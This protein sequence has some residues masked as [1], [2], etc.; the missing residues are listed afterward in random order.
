MV[1][2]FDFRIEI[3][4]CPSVEMIEKENSIKLVMMGARRDDTGIYTLKADNDHGQDQA[5][6]EVVVMV[7]PSKPRGPMK[8]NDIVADGCL[9]EWSAPE[10]DGG[11]PITQYIIE[12]AEGASVNWTVCGQT[13]GDVTKCRVSGLK[14]GKDHR[15]QVDLDRS[16]HDYVKTKNSRSDLP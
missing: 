11:T 1:L 5:D 13:K 12:K 14:M 2:T 16:L 6:V 7:E 3:K 9:A 8:I 15:L 4:A 10:D